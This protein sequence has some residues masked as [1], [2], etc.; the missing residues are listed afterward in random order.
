MVGLVEVGLFGNRRSE[1]GATVRDGGGIW[2]M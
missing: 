1:R 2:G